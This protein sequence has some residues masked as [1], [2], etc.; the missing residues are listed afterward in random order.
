MLPTKDPIHKLLQGRLMRGIYYSLFPIQLSRLNYKKLQIAALTEIML[1]QQSSL[2][3]Y[4]ILT[5]TGCEH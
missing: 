4:H 3:S 5:S 2:L 1:V